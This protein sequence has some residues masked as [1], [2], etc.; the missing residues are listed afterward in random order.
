M[1]ACI[2]QIRVKQADG[3]FADV[4]CGRCGFCLSNRRK[5]WSF[6]LQ[7]EMRYHEKA[8]F[9]T[10]TY[11]DS[12]LRVL[13]HI[14]TA[15]GECYPIPV[16]DKQDLRKFFKR[17]RYEQKLITDDKIKY[18][19]VGEYGGKTGRPHYHAIIF[20]A[21]PIID[22]QKV[23]QLGHVDVGDV[24]KDSIDYIT[25]YVVNRMD[26]KHY[27]VPPFSS[28]SNGI[29]LQH[30]KENQELYKKSD[31]VRNARGYR[32]KLPRYYADKLKENRWTKKITSAKRLVEYEANRVKEID[33]LEKIGHQDAEAYIDE[34]KLHNSQKV[35]KKAKDNTTL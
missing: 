1:A 12:N 35:L 28:I 30:F 31:I 23:W 19:A 34:R 16:L 25:K 21:E 18:Y 5:E 26:Q 10:L 33:R 27:L 15:T 17:L 13:D 11:T 29:G 32:Q 9:I 7:K 3:S 14:N 22:V 6:R 4:P 20:G 2:S 24:N 8:S